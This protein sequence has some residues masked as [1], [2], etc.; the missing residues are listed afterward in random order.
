VPRNVRSRGFCCSSSPGTAVLVDLETN[1]ETSIEIGS[2]VL[3]EGAWASNSRL[4]VAAVLNG[5]RTRARA[6]LVALSDGGVTT[7][8]QNL[9]GLLNV[10]WS[11]DSCEF[12]FLTFVG[13]TNQVELNR[14]RLITRR[15]TVRPSEKPF[16]ARPCSGSTEKV[17]R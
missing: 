8:T 1:N 16:G 11:L 13:A 2:G 9:L 3:S 17:D 12:G 10:L 6:A 7:Y 14:F 5:T 15:R 4:F